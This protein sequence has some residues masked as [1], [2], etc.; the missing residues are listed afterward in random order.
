MDKRVVVLGGGIAGLSAAIILAESGVE[1]E[2]IEKRSLLGGISATFTCK[3]TDSCQQCGACIVEEALKKALSLPNINFYL[4]TKLVAVEKN[5]SFK[6]NIAPS[7][8]PPNEIK[9]FSRYNKEKHLRGKRGLKREIEADAIIIATGFSPFDP[10]KRPTYGYGQWKDVITALEMEQMLREK[11]M[12]LRPSD[13]KKAK[14][15]AFIQCVGSRNAQF[16]ALWC[17]E[18]CCPY[19]LRMGAL[20]KH[21]DPESDIWVFFIDLQNIGKENFDFIKNASQKMRLLNIVPVD[22]FEDREKRVAVAFEEGNIRKRESFDL[23]V[24]SI[25]IAPNEDNAHLA[26]LFGIDGEGGG[27]L[28]EKSS[29][30]PCVTSTEGVFLAGTVTGPKGILDT[31][32]HA[33]GAAFETLTY[34][35]GA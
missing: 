30:T 10:R 28:K 32:S 24:L 16:N 18:V 34:L 31:I 7:S 5:Q 3:A 8:S 20:I 12:V 26:Q 14:K 4:G 17:S 22:I 35:G 27:F 29:T 2:V 9:P 33:R 25:G 23:V 1:V 13:G 11:G 15:I 19:A 6:L 21:R